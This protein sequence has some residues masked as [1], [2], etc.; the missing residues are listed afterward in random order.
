MGLK[1]APAA[2]RHPHLRTVLST[3]L[4]FACF[5]L[6]D[7]MELTP[8]LKKNLVL[9]LNKPPA[10]RISDYMHPHRRSLDAF[11]LT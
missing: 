9:T 3:N 6:H 11:R 4:N 5:V 2:T 10:N 1:P 7:L 8:A